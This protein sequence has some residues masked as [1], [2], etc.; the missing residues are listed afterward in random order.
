MTTGT[1]AEQVS[2]M[3]AGMAA[4]PPNE[5][6]GSFTREQ[7]D[8]AAHGIPNGVAATGASLPDADLLDA[9]GTPATLYSVTGGR[10]AVIVFYRGVWCPYCNLALSTYQA[11]L[12]PALAGRDVT[13]IAVSPQVA[14]ES[15]SMQQKNALAFPVVSDPCNTLARFLGI[16]S[17]PS[18]EARAA[19]LQLGLDLTTVNADGTT[20][21]PMPTTVIVDADHVIRWIDVHPDY[22]TRSEPA[23]IVAALDATNLSPS[24]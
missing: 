10:P 8:L 2:T 17:A 19:Q 9:H 18:S 5:I 11:H 4:Q 15:L 6:M 22:S 23:E 13:L 1:I 3:L 20:A 7:A 21:V 14:D 16:L 24:T 12:L